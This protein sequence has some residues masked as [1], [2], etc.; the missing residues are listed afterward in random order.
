MR[1]VLVLIVA[2]FVTVL[3]PAGTA[4]GAIYRVPI[5]GGSIRMTVPAGWEPN[6]RLA[7]DNGAVAFLN[8]TG[9]TAGME[10]PVWIVVDLRPHAVGESGHGENRSVFEE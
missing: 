6:P 10:I 3:L 7:G 4:Q 2:G 8:P 5:Q 1:S 9:L